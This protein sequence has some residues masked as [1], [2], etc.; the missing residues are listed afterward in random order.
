[1]T[2][3]VLLCSAGKSSSGCTAVVKVL[4]TTE[5]V[6]ALLSLHL[7]RTWKPMRRAQMEGS[8]GK[9]TPA[10][11]RVGSSCTFVPGTITGQPRH[12]LG[13][14]KNPLQVAF[15]TI[16][17]SVVPGL[18]RGLCCRERALPSE[19]SGKSLVTTVVRS[20]HYTLQHVHK[21]D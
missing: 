15:R 8:E 20:Q 5:A 10:K 18:S 12:E 1:M 6:P 21:R 11:G 7:D 16:S 14:A 13:P 9:K 3:F 19:D 17:V 2:Q 4:Q